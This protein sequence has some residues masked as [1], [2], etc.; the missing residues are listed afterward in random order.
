MRADNDNEIRIADSLEILNRFL[1]FA[2]RHGHEAPVFGPAFMID[3]PY[4]TDIRFKVL[5]V[6]LSQSNIVP[7]GN[8]VCQSLEFFRGLI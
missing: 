7:V 1:N 6:Y 4:E 3:I 5:H 8:S 2:V